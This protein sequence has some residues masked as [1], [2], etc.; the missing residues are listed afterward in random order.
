MAT[1]LFNDIIFGP[2]QS[3]RLGV[4]LGIN[5]LPTDNKIC[6]FDCIYCECGWNNKTKAGTFPPHAIVVEALESRLTKMRDED[7]LPD[8]ITFAGNGEPTVH[9]EFTKI[10][11]ATIILRDQ[12]SPKTKIAV[13]TN[14]TMLHSQNIIDALLKIDRAILKLDSAL[15]STRNLINIPAKKTSTATLLEQFS[16]FGDKLVMQTL[17][18]TAENNGVVIDNTTEEEITA[19]L[20]AYKQLSPSEVMIYCI[21]RDTPLKTA[22][23]I[24]KQRMDEIAK[25]I[26]ALGIKVSVSY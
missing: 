18:L 6:N 3:R 20:A 22:S 12:Y 21:D 15:E 1:A 16:K 26:S 25:R 8:V 24:P 23:K 4:S 11:D 14:A 10:I 17:F 5:L 7:I 19:L 13:L 2:V 9:P